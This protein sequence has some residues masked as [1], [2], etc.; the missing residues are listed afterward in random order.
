[1]ICFLRSGLLL[2][3]LRDILKLEKYAKRIEGIPML[4]RILSMIL[5]LSMVLSLPAQ[6]IAL[7]TEEPT[8][9]LQETEPLTEE[10]PV[11]EEDPIAEEPKPAEELQPTEET[12]PVEEETAP[13]EEMTELEQVPML[14]DSSI[15]AS[16][17][18][19]DNANWYISDKTLMING[20]GDM[21]D[22]DVDE[23]PWDDYISSGTSE[24]P[25]ITSIQ[26]GNQITSIG[27]YAFYNG[28]GITSISIGSGVKKIGE[29]SCQFD[30]LETLELPNSLIEIEDF[31]FGWCY[32][33]KT[34]ELPES[35]EILGHGS[36]YACHALTSVHIPASVHDYAL[37]TMLGE[38][39]VFSLCSGI[40]AFTV[41]PRNSTLTAQ[42]G[43]LFNKDMTCLIQYPLGCKN[44]NYSIPESV[45][46]VSGSVFN[47]SQFLKSVVVPASVQELDLYAFA[48]CAQLQEI[49]FLGDAPEFI[50]Y[51]LFT[52][53]EVIVYYPIGNVSWNTVTERNFAGNVT[54]QPAGP[55]GEVAG[56]YGDNIFWMVDQNIDK[57][58]VWGE[59]V[60][61]GKTDGTEMPWYPYRGE[62]TS[63]EVQ[64]GVTYIPYYAFEFLN[65]LETVVLPEGLH[66]LALSAFNYC[67]KVNNLLIPASVQEITSPYSF[68]Q[69]TS[70]TDLYYLGTQEE[71]RNIRNAEEVKNSS[72]EMEIHFLE[73]HEDPPTC[74]KD[75]TQSYYQFS[76]TS[77]YGGM[78]DTKKILITQIEKIPA[79]GHTEV[80]DKAVDAT[81]TS[82]GL[83]EGRHCSTCGEVFTAQTVIPAGHSNVKS[84]ICAS[85]GLFGTCGENVT[86]SLDSKTGVMTISGVGAMTDFNGATEQPW[87]N[88][89]NDISALV[90]EDGV[91]TIGECAFA[92]CKN[93]KSIDF[94]RV[95]SIGRYAFGRCESLTGEIVIPDSVVNMEDLIF[96][97]T[98]V[99]TITFTGTTV[100]TIR[101]D[102][103]YMSSLKYVYVPGESLEGYTAALSVDRAIIQATSSEVTQGICG[104]NLT[105]IFDESSCTLSISG[106]GAMDNYQYNIGAPWSW[107]GH[108]SKITNIVL[109]DGIT[110]IGDYA[111][112]Y[113]DN[114]GGKLIIPDSVTSMGMGAFSKCGSI[115]VT[116]GS[117]LKEIPTS[118]FANSG[119]TVVDFGAISAISDYAFS[120]C[121][122]LNGD[123]VIPDSVISMGSGAFNDCDCIDTLT[124]G[125]G[126]KILPSGA[127]MSCDD[128]KSIDMASVAIIED[129]AFH[130]CKNLTSV[131]LK[132][133]TT[134]GWEAFSVCES[135]TGE[136]V[137]PD[138]VTVIGNSSFAECINLTS[139]IMG[140]GLTDMQSDN[141]T[142]PFYGCTGV[143]KITF[144][145][146]AVPANI[147]DL[148]SLTALKTVYVPADALDAYTTALS[149]LL[150]ENVTVQAMIENRLILDSEALDGQSTVWIDGAEMAIQK[151]GDFWYID[152]PDGNARVMTTYG[153]VT[154]GTSEDGVAEHVRYPVSMQVWTLEN[155]D[156]VYTATRQTEFDDILRYSGVAIRVTGKQG[157][158]MIT[159]IEETDKDALTGAGLAGY[160]LLEYGTAIAWADQIS[161]T[162]PLTLGRSYVSS[163]FAYSKAEGKDPIFAYK[164]NCI[165]YTNVLVGFDLDQCADDLAMRP[166]MILADADGNEITIYGGIVNRSIG[167]IALRNRLAFSNE[168]DAYDFIWDIIH[169]VYG[170]A[171]D[172]D[173]QPTWTDTIL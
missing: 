2:Y 84:A 21:Y 150:P 20:S 73:L 90:M 89:Q 106:S 104:E 49:I 69:C 31:A 23:A 35:L 26:I 105:W 74:T 39:G 127:F 40:T 93:L 42:D 59:G 54:W 18:C 100:P 5:C 50:S 80:V 163:N 132:N 56:I 170:D 11:V 123:L 95:V 131:D 133:V 33:L 141:F 75:G 159:S 140:S 13:A 86:W 94:G 116:V 118:A 43:V 98:K 107:Y 79:L 57:L 156:G 102:D 71:W 7:E 128:L 53:S 77:V 46:I 1:M 111:F 60:I 62:I 154:D 17:T 36:F 144:T 22:Y 64:S 99:S 113:C 81:C 157:I 25:N 155:K 97:L 70:L 119:V 55:N 169:A 76:N 134:I 44:T 4:K 48:N 172:A 87:Y 166:Y 129:G 19:G 91:T 135:L 45:T 142:S 101:W 171:Y 120:N 168:T 161:T 173:W 52:G 125:N 9:T 137:I 164:N 165:Q 24:G 15:I 153:Y 109:E 72:V 124:I 34:V 3:E 65:E 96:D 147:G 143:Q 136:L 110:S 122:S 10:E 126:L 68:W 38:Q 115:Q 47:N 151:D 114:L 30:Q 152:L 67:P 58:T 138:T 117:G 162:S 92:L 32:N 139:V 112:R 160:T 83:T 66:T 145:G 130:A 28:W 12:E 82:S 6:A 158:R 88:F 78:Y 29:Y 167:Y 16:G 103:L 149:D 14:A 41:D 61:D 148:T 63:L 108:R 51:E 121:D 37:E 146:S 8:E 85:C 27:D